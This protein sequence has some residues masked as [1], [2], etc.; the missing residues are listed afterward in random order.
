MQIEK[1]STKAF[2]EHEKEEKSKFSPTFENDGL[3]FPSDCELL[4]ES[5]EI[6]IDKGKLKETLPLFKKLNEHIEQQT[7]NK[8]KI[9]LRQETDYL[10]DEVEEWVKKKIMFTGD[11]EMIRFA[12]KY[13]QIGDLVGIY[14]QY[15]MIKLKKVI[16]KI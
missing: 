2:E 4:M 5:I 13:L 16:S 8:V 7:N 11:K 3:N 12:R 6:A 1:F 14:L 10:R 9:M 15:Q